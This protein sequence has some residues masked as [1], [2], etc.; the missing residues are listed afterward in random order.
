MGSIHL[1]LPFPLS[2]NMLYANRLK[3]RTKSTRYR[4]WANA[5]G[6]ELKAQKQTPLHGWYTMRLCLYEADKR[7]RDPGNM[8]KCISDLL[9]EHG[10]VEDDSLCVSVAIERFRTRGKPYCE[11]TVQASNGIPESEAA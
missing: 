7:K 4:T 6:W 8:E 10:L 5:A 11:V 9:V 3:S 1:K 2:V